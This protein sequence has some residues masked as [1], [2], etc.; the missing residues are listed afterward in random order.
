MAPVEH[1]AAVGGPGV[2]D[3]IWVAPVEHEAAVGDP[4]VSGL[5]CKPVPFESSERFAT[6]LVEGVFMD[7]CDVVDFAIASDA[8][9]IRIVDVGTITPLTML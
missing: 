6:D 7:S 1:E 8:S 4:G 3:L 2:S 5:N 9:D